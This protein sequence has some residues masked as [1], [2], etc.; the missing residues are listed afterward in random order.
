MQGLRKF[1]T[2]TLVKRSEVPKGALV[3]GLKEILKVKY[4]EDGSLDKYKFRITVQ[5]Y[6]QKIKRE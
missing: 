2:Y 1:N 5:G 3:M 6:S 4:N